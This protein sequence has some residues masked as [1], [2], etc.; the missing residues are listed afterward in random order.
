MF[1]LSLFFVI[2]KL[3][4]SKLLLIDLFIKDFLYALIPNEGNSSLGRLAL[5]PNEGNSSLGYK[6]IPFSYFF[7]ILGVILEGFI[8]IISSS[9]FFISIY[10]FSFSVAYVFGYSGFT[11]TTFFSSL[12]IELKVFFIF[13]PTIS[14]ISTIFLVSSLTIELKVFFSSPPL[15]ESLEYLL[16]YAYVEISPILILFLISEEL[17]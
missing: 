4:T 12:I 1:K 6:F 15:F 10:I 16:I 3:S 14:F 11:S 5:I 8:F 2:F 13:S 17:F 7:S 9:F